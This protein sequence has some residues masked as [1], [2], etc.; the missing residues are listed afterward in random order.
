MSYIEIEIDHQLL[1]E[2]CT[3]IMLRWIED[4]WI[5][6]LTSVSY[7]A[8]YTLVESTLEPIDILDRGSYLNHELIC[9]LKSVIGSNITFG[10]LI[11]DDRSLPGSRLCK[12]IFTNVC[13]ELPLG[14]PASIE[15]HQGFLTVVYYFHHTPLPAGF[16]TY[17]QRVSLPYS[18]GKRD[19]IRIADFTSRIFLPCVTGEFEDV[20]LDIAA[21]PEQ[22]WLS[23]PRFLEDLSINKSNDSDSRKDCASVFNGFRLA[24]GRYCF[25]VDLSCHNCKK[26]MLN[27]H[28][29]VG[30]DEYIDC[31]V[32]IEDH[33]SF[34]TP[35]WQIYSISTYPR[36]RFFSYIFL[37]VDVLHSSVKLFLGE[38]ADSSQ[39][40]TVKI[41]SMKF[42]QIYEE[43]GH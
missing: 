19:G 25:E 12:I 41:H 26:V 42:F 18:S 5:S 29:C 4:L 21:N 31:Q 33:I 8:L 3:D 7:Q 23:I 22:T 37:P 27:L 20:S 17:E 34:N 6:R 32:R 2:D 40:S 24:A 11:Q 1:A 28:A 10:S 30:D 15:R 35:I 36:M 16:P 43:W 38:P 14:T 9:L 39:I 13:S